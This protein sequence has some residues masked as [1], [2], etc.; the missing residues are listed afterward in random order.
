MTLPRKSASPLPALDRPC[1]GEVYCALMKHSSHTFHSALMKS[2]ASLGEI[3]GA[4]LFPCLLVP[5]N[6]CAH[7]DPGLEILD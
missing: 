7:S 3:L 2:K 1:K 5:M 4:E 6:M